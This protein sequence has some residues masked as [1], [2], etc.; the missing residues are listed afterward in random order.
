MARKDKLTDRKRPS[1]PDLINQWDDQRTRARG[2]Y[3][4]D[5]IFPTYDLR[6]VGRE[7]FYKHTLAPVPPTK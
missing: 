4:L 3:V 5:D 7:G 1:D 6:A 2:K